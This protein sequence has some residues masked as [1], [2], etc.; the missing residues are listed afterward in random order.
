M[1]K[2]N[3]VLYGFLTK[4]FIINKLKLLRIELLALLDN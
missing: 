2:R 1:L 3:A 4:N